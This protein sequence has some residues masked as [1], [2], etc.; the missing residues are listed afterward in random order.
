MI[1]CDIRYILFVTE[2]LYGQ[3][4]LTDEMDFVRTEE[5]SPSK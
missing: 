5:P 3:K 4:R 1:T 2:E